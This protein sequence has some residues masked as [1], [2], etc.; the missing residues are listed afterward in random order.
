MIEGRAGVFGLG[1]SLTHVGEML[2]LS[3]TAPL[4]LECSAATRPE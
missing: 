1:D 3:L 4:F 2:C